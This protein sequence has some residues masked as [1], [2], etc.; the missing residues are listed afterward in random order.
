MATKP[1]GNICSIREQIIDD[2]V[3]ELTFQFEAMTD[4]TSRLRI[5]GDLPF[6][7]REFIF[8][9]EGNEAGA[10]TA[11]VSQCRPSWLKVK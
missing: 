2:P 3:S 4:G 11:L 1:D 7:N 6:G 10:G 5:Y 8:D 9:G